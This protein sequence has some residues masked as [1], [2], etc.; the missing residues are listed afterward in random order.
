MNKNFLFKPAFKLLPGEELIFKTHPHWLFVVLPVAGL[1][2]IWYLYSTLFC[3][4]FMI[5][6]FRGLCL[7]AAS[8]ALPFVI[9]LFYLDWQLCRLYLTNMRLIKERGIIGRRCMAIFL[10]QVEDITCSQGL[11]GRVLGYGDLEIES[12]GTFG[13]MVYRQAPKPVEK[14]AMIEQALARIR[15]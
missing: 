11:W 6:G 8:F 1:A 2:V 10:E 4:S 5:A 13:R 15:Q 9:V 3:P 14:K 12:A 7:A